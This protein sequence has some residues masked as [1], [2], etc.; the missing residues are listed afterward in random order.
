MNLHAFIHRARRE[1]IRFR[2]EAGVSAAEEKG[3][4]LFMSLLMLLLFSYEVR[5]GAHSG[6]GARVPYN[7]HWNGFVFRR[8]NWIIFPFFFEL[9]WLF[10]YRRGRRLRKTSGL[11]GVGGDGGV[12]LAG[13][14]RSSTVGLWSGRGRRRRE[15][16]DGEAGSEESAHTLDTFADSFKHGTTTLALQGGVG[17]L[18]PSTDNTFPLPLY[19]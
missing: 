5:V 1:T 13:R 15:L 10:P 19:C 4:S 3:S 14:V 6:R 17:S 2:F 12:R 18:E 8:K 9:W 11:G 7:E 16:A